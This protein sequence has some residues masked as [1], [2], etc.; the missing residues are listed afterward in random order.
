MKPEARAALGLD[1]SDRVGR[2]VVVDAKG[3]VLA[4]G[5]FVRGSSSLVR[6]VRE[7]IKRATTAAG[8]PARVMGL[9]VPLPGDQ[10]QPDVVAAMVELAPGAGLPA[11]IAAGPAA[12]LAEHWCGAAVDART[13]VAFSLGE[14]VTTGFL[15]NGEPWHGASNLAGS[16]GWLAVNPVEREDYRRL[17][18][19]ESEVAAASIVRRLVW[20]VKSGDYSTLTDQTEG[21]ASRMSA[22]DVLE[23]ARKGDGVCISV[24]RDTAKYS[25]MAVANLITMLDPEVVVLGGMIVSAGDILFEP[26]RSE[27]ARRVSPRPSD[28]LRILLS[29]LGDDAVA[30]G[31]ARAALRQR[32]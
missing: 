6:E 7:A 2:V 15:V 19:L 22:A 9:A 14:H 32:A 30:I 24:V 21:D 13:V 5:E 20:R 18:G 8:G 23:E 17:G 10:G 27:C 28:R 1:L 25:G 26:I 11:V 3:R 16:I 4:R 31:A 29:P 12:A